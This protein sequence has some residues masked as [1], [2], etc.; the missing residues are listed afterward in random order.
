VSMIHLTARQEQIAALADHL[1]ARFAERAPEHERTGTFP[2]QNYADLHE[3]GFLRLI[4]PPEYGGDGADLL[5]MVVALEHLAR[6]DGSTAMAV[7]M[8]VHMIGR[9]RETRSWPEP[10]FA[11]VCRAIVREGALINAAA[12]EPE[13]GSPSR[14]NMPATTATPVEG[15]YLLRGHKQFV[16]MAP[17]LRYFVVSCAL[18][19]S[20]DAPQGATANALIERGAPGLR[21]EDTWSGALSLRASGSFDVLLEDVFVPEGRLVDRQAVGQPPPL[22]GKSPASLAWFALTL[23]AVYLGIGQGASDTIR[24]Y[25]RTRVPTALGKPIAT[26]PN[27]QRRVGEVEIALSAARSVLH[28]TA[29]QWVEHPERREAM[30]PQIA[31]AKYLCTNAAAS[32]TDGALRIAGGFGITN[33]LPLERFFR[34]ARAGLTHPP[35][36]DTALE[37]VGKAALEG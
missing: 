19:P 14:G 35:N 2:Q 5:D 21:L 16:S 3:A 23:S 17:A 10:I 1:A 22:S 6:G 13:M 15:G 24:D 9:L 4:V 12:S 18:P 26:L 20:E 25:A 30:P 11:E 37:M 32:A 34:D 36:D 7:D 33:R 31:I 28:H 29:R 8:T 27:I